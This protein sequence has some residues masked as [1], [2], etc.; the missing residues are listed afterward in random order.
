MSNIR[1]AIDGP[2][3]SGK[4]T[5]AK[6]IAKKYNLK[7]INTGLVYRALAFKLIEL[8]INI[9][10]EDKVKENIQN[11]KINLLEN[12]IVDLNGVKLDSELR[13]DN[14]SQASSVI[15]SY[16]SVRNYAVKIQMLEASRKGVIMDG[17]DT[18]FKIMPDADFKFFLDTDAEIRAK[19]RVEQNSKIGFSTDYEKILS[20]IKI[21]DHRDRTREVDPLHQTADAHLIDTS[22]MTIENVVKEIIEIIEKDTL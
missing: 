22:E 17:R 3:G 14:V 5:I 1:I 4:S 9:Q 18:T 2:S 20:E 21:R 11:I 7:Y 12:E 10:N 15:A 16:S 13:S 6:L 19:R 8:G